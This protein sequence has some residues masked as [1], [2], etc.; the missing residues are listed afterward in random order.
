MLDHAARRVSVAHSWIKLAEGNR[1]GF[2]RDAKRLEILNKAHADAYERLVRLCEDRSTATNALD[3][4]R[5]RRG[6]IS[7][8]ERVVKAWSRKDCVTPED[9]MAAAREVHAD[10]EN[11]KPGDIQLYDALAGEDACCVWRVAGGADPKILKDYVAG[12]D[13]KARQA[14]FKVPAYRH[15]DPLRHPVFCD[16]GVSRW[17]IDF[18]VHRAYKGRAS[19]SAAFARKKAALEK[20]EGAVASARDAKQKESAEAKLNVAREKFLEIARSWS[21]STRRMGCG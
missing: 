15:P 20:A 16:F 2:R 1:Q 12:T 8:W 19:L 9:R 11:E 17:G 13:A 6:A 14:R 10:P 21:F 7:D 3:A 4:Y 5:I 18:A